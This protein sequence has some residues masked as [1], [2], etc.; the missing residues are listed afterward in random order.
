MKVKRQAGNPLT[1]RSLDKFPPTRQT[2]HLRDEMVLRRTRASSALV[3]DDGSEVAIIR[4][5][6]C[7]S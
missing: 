7:V 4:Q 2:F 3:E 6:H 5:K 1:L